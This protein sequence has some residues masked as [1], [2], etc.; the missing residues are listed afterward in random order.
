MS[1]Q[2]H[3]L[4]TETHY[5]QLVEAGIKTFELRINDRNFRVGDMITLYETVQG[6]ATGRELPPKEIKYILEGGRFG[7]PA[8][9]CII[10]L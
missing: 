3:R 1:R 9:H 7:L 8:T 10:Q 5:Y 4:K 6:V 2:H